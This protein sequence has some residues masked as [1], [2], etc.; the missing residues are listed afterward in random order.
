MSAANELRPIPGLDGYAACADGSLW[1]EM[2]F[3]G[4]GANRVMYKSGV[5][6]KLPA[7]PDEHGYRIIRMPGSVVGVKKSRKLYVHSLILLAFEGPCPP[8]MECRHLNGD[9]ADCRW[10]N[11]AWG[12]RSTNQMDRVAHGTSNR[13]ERHP[14]SKLTL[15]QVLAIRQPLKPGDTVKNRALKHGISPR[16]A[17]VIRSRWSWAWTS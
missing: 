12:T 9:R 11:L 15:E 6:R 5:W 2:R 10:E 17:Y 13:G 3:R 1:T 7:G 4:R 14:M 16:S 8:G